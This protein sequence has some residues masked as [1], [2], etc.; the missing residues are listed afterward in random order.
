MDKVQGGSKGGQKTCT[1]RTKWTTGA[2]GH[3]C[4]IHARPR[5]SQEKRELKVSV[6]R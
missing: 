4:K 5:R 3:R 6:P 2:V 1:G